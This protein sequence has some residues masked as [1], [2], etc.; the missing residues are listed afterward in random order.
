M[1]FKSKRMG[2]AGHRAHSHMGDN[3]N[4]YSIFRKP[5]MKK[6]L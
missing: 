3:K 5:E 6:P 1:I 4:M 2:W